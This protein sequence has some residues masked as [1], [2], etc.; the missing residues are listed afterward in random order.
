MAKSP[1]A[2]RTISEVAVWLG[3]PTHVL[4]FW[5]S[6]FTQVKPVKR[7]GGRRYYRPADMELLGGIKHLLH[8]D[9]L[10]IRGVQKLLREQGIK[11]VAAYS[12]PVN[13]EAPAEPPEAAFAPPRA[14][15]EPPPDR[16]PFDDAAKGSQEPAAPP[17][18]D[19]AWEDRAHAEDPAV[20]PGANATA[21]KGSDTPAS[22]EIAGDETAPAGEAVAAP[23]SAE[24]TA[25]LG[26]EHAVT[27]HNGP[28]EADAVVTRP[29]EIQVERQAGP[30]PTETAAAPRTDDIPA[31]PPGV[32]PHSEPEARDFDPDALDIP[33]PII[34]RIARTDPARFAAHRD[35]LRGL[36]DRAQSLARSLNRHDD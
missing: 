32:T 13:G 21:R 23:G 2:F 4:R 24:D 11:H 8:E 1:D 14:F 16:W 36:L 33:D 29:V 19:A 17:P 34:A 10:T 6:R 26:E 20:P 7:A 28:G 9:G 3:V 12:P 18:A 30:A 15:A 31:D 27:D 25:D 22:A 35:R 5:E